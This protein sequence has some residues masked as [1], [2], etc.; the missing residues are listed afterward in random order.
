MAGP[1][2]RLQ[3]SMEFHLQQL[4]GGVWLNKN[5]L[6]RTSGIVLLHIQD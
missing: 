3:K 2:A 4:G 6:P 1:G 5:Y